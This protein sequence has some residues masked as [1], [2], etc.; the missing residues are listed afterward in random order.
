MGLSSRK[1]RRCHRRA[2]TNQW[3]IEVSETEGG[4]SRTAAVPHRATSQRR[5]RSKWSPHSRAAILR[6]IGRRA[7]E[8]RDG[9]PTAPPDHGPEPDDQEVDRDPRARSCRARLEMRPTYLQ[10][11]WSAHAAHSQPD[12]DRAVDRHHQRGWTRIGRIGPSIN[13]STASSCGGSSGH[14][15]RAPAHSRDRSNRP[16]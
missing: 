16:A 12:R 13:R 1:N 3:E 6:S 7:G 10:A 11:C 2:L 14:A 15:C 4:P 8:E 9:Q 5:H